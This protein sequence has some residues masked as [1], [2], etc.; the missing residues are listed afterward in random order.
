MD[1]K[2]WCQYGKN[3]IEQYCPPLCFELAGRE[4]ELAMD[5][6]YDF[7]LNFTDGHTLKWQQ[8]GGTAQTAPY[9]CLKG[10]E[11]TYLVSYELTGVTPRVHH[12]FVL[13]MENMLVTRIIARVGQ[14]PRFPYL[15]NTDFTFGAIRQEGREL[16]FRRHGF[17]SDMI[18]S[19]VQWA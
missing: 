18:G 9:K 5:D 19:A 6:G 12:T 13:D 4:F 3:S 2:N 11:T 10:D 7:L 15:V 8:N 14:N 17:T 16:P 1:L